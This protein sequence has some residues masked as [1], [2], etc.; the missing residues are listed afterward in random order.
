MS[1]K[2]EIQGVT[3][4]IYNS[5]SVVLNLETTLQDLQYLPNHPPTKIFSKLTK[6]LKTSSQTF[7]E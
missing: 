6:N 5:T 4:M 3:G 2:V 1:L 7:F